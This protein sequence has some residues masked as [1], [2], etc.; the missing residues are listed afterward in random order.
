M[1]SDNTRSEA[2]VQP[3]DNP[4]KLN[5]KRRGIRPKTKNSTSSPN[6]AMRLNWI[7]P[8]PQVD[9]ISPIGIEPNIDTIPAGEIEL[10]F[11]LPS[12][13]SDPFTEV[14]HSVGDRL[15]LD[16]DQKQEIATHLHAIGYF[17]AARQLFST[18]LDH[19]KA[20]NQPLKAVYYDETPIPVHMAGA[21]GIIGHMETKVGP[22]HIRDAGTLFKRWIVKGLQISGELDNEHNPETL[23]WGDKESYRCVQRLARDR[24]DLLVQQTYTVDSNG[25]QYTVSMPQLRAQDLQ[26]YYTQINNHVPNADDLRHCIQAMQMTWQQWRTGENI[27]NNGDRD[28]ICGSLG[29]QWAEDFASPIV[30]RE[31]FEEFCATHTTRVRAKLASLYHVGPPPA[32]TSGYGAQIVSSRGNQAHWSFPLSDSDVNIGYLFSP[33]RS[34]TLNP[35]LVGYSTRRKEAAA[36]QFAAADGKAP[37]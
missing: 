1:S 32:G 35:R 16:D 23:I 12:S 17:K 26:D 30:L 29:L 19:E 5:A 20:A 2:Q 14:V 31:L 13:I 6:N 27:P 25:H 24:V 37:V 34:F 21:L 4:N 8:L 9:V 3:G 36:A 18:F 11:F 22:V 7:D 15:T 28:D 33:N 10:D